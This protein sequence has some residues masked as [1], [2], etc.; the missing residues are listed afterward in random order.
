MLIG[1]DCLD[2]ILPIQTRIDPQGTPVGICTKL[3]WTIT[4]PMPEHVR[5]SEAIFFVHI[6]SPNEELHNKVKSGSGIQRK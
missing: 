6:P 3:G 4:G 5:D 1:S 2:I